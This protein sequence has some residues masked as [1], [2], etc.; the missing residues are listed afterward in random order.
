MASRDK[1]MNG[2][3]AIIALAL[4]GC[5]RQPD[6]TAVQTKNGSIVIEADRK[7][8]TAPCVYGVTIYDQAAGVH[9][10]WSIYLKEG[11]RSKCTNRFV[12]PSIPHGYYMTQPS[13][14]LRPGKY[15]VNATGV[16]FQARA[17]LIISNRAR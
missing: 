2:V 9:T 5:H 17:D 6:F 11:Q 14:P 1:V 12:Y 16:G 4:L 13:T 7:G 3:G 15:Q 8:D 10:D